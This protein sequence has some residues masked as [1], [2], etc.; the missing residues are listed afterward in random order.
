MVRWTTDAYGV[1]LLT[2][3]TGT[4]TAEFGLHIL[5]QMEHRGS[6]RQNK[7]EEALSLMC[8]VNALL[9]RMN[10]SIARVQTT[11]EDAHALIKDN[12]IV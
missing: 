2:K 9:L 3:P 6:S 5:C 11:Q 1:F 12:F 7:G 10:H 8:N 4:A